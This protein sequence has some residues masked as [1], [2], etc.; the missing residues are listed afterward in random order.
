MKKMIIGIAS[1]QA[2]RARAL[3]RV[4][5]TNCVTECHHS[6]VS[7]TRSSPNISWKLCSAGFQ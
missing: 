5:Q 2:I 6:A 3:A 7:G 4:C 1:Q